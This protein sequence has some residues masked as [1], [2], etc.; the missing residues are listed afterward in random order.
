MRPPAWISPLLL[1]L[2]VAS[3]DARGQMPEL[4]RWIDADGVVRYTPNPNYVPAA[5]RGTLARVE[6]GMAKPPE[7]EHVVKPAA[8]FVP[9]GEPALEA[10]PFNAPA[11]ARRVEAEIVAPVP[12]QTEAP[13]QRPA[14]TAATAPA[15]PVP[16]PAAAAAAPPGDVVPIAG[17][18]SEIVSLDAPSDEAAP[19]AATLPAAPPVA[20]VP[21]EIPP[22]AAVAPV[23]APVAAG[24][25]LAPVAAVAPAVAPVAAGPELAP[26]A[27]PP[28]VAVVAPEP[29]S[30]A[31]APLPPELE[32]RRAQLVAEIARDEEALK[33]HVSAAGDQP[34]S[35]SPELREI[36]HRLPALQAELRALEA[37]QDPR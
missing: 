5:Q 31:V 13:A 14:P 33:A 17:V 18:E 35:A 8:I 2:A 37:Q 22:R 10:D 24:P 36:A 1:A 21:P 11:P 20:S 28:A 9:P 23:V 19:L 16:R 30:V 6:L 12:L 3:Q 27:V 29:P 32:A 25:E 4:W 34:L 26:V 15:A 7:P